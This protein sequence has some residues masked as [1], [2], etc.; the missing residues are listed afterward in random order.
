MIFEFY[1]DKRSNINKYKIKK[2]T[3]RLLLLKITYVR[4]IENVYNIYSLSFK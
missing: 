2:E 3:E 4:N 1:H